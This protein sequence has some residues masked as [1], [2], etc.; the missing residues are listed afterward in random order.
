M[1]KRVLVTSLEHCGTG[2]PY[3]NCGALVP[4]N[5]VPESKLHL[6][7][8]L[9]GERVNWDV[10]ANGSFPEHCGLPE[11]TVG[12]VRKV[13]LPNNQVMVYDRG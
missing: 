10:I 3:F 4:T 5:E 13:V 8:T 2:C 6:H 12:P 11:F 9:S 1:N 7:C